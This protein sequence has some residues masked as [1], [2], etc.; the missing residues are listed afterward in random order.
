MIFRQIVQVLAHIHEMIIIHRDLSRSNIFLD[1]DG[2]VKVGD[3]GLDK[4][5]LK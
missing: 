5:K 2:N 4:L 1:E 3:F